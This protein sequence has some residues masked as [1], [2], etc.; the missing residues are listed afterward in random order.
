MTVKLNP[1]RFADVGGA[2]V[3]GNVQTNK[4]ISVRGVPG[5]SNGVDGVL[6]TSS[7]LVLALF[8]TLMPTSE[9]APRILRGVPVKAKIKIGDILDG[10]YG[11][12][13]DEEH[14]E[15]AAQAAALS[16]IF[17]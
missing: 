5:V 12:A 3:R 17:M 15:E 16:V 8:A 1:L 7:F 13:L 9:G 14:H 4:R 6:R 10:Q 11:Q 2:H